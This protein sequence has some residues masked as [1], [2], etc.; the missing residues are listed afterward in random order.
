MRNFTVLAAVALITFFASPI[1]AADSVQ[2]SNER[3]IDTDV[4]GHFS[5]TQKPITAQHDS[6]QVVSVERAPRGYFTENSASS[7]TSVQSID[8]SRENGGN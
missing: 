4:S 1:M 6:V 5:G 8:L 7:A 2:L 3:G